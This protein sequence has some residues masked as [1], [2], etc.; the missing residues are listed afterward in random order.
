MHIAYL[1]MGVIGFSFAL[2]I[3]CDGQE[4]TDLLL[5]LLLSGLLIWGIGLTFMAGLAGVEYES[6]YSK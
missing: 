1:G 4:S 6:G 5:G 2:D 3:V